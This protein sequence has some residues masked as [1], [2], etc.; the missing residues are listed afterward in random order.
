MGDV[1]TFV[2]LFL[3]P[4][5]TTAK[6]FHWAGGAGGAGGFH[7]LHGC[8]CLEESCKVKGGRSKVEGQR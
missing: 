7:G 3:D 1:G 8:F 4:G 6:L 5:E 2:A